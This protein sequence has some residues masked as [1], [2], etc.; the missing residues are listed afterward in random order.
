MTTE[1]KE[2][3]WPDTSGDDWP[4][5]VHVLLR[6]ET[7]TFRT[8]PAPWGMEVEYVLNADE[9]SAA[10]KIYPSEV[11]HYIEIFEYIKQRENTNND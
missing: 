10:F 5:D 7:P 6:T 3:R 2:F 8:R 1:I 11:D 4:D 9:P